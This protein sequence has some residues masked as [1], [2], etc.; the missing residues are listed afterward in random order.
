MNRH[1]VHLNIYFVFYR[2]SIWPCSKNSIWQGHTTMNNWVSTF[3]SIKSGI[4]SNDKK[5]SVIISNYVHIYH[6]RCHVNKTNHP[7]YNAWLRRCAIY[8]SHIVVFFALL[9]AY[10]SVHVST[11]GDCVLYEE[12]YLTNAPISK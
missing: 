8:Q 12:H 5:A 4:W 6:N 3:S 1:S 10:I 9:G 7:T 2:T 11:D